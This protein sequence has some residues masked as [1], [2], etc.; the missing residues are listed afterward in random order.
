VEEGR[1]NGLSNQ[2]VGAN[3]IEP[4]TS[5]S[6]NDLPTNSYRGKS[7]AFVSMC[8]LPT[9]IIGTLKHAPMTRP[10][11]FQRTGP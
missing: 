7:T 9:D 5:I 1:Q 8:S 11:I 3:D 2:T 6:Q 4:I 10:V